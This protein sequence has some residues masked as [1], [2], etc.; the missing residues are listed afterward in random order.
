VQPCNDDKRQ[1]TLTRNALFAQSKRPLRMRLVVI[2]QPMT[3]SHPE[4]TRSLLRGERQ[5]LVENWL[6]ARRGEF[7]C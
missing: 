7:G 5:R 3:A 4:P 2:D 1:V 6:D